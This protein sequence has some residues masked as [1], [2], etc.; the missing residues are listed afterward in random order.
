MSSP[1]GPAATT[2]MG[3]LPGEDMRKWVSVVLDVVSIPFLPELPARPYGDMVSRAAG[4][5]TQLALDLQPAGWRLTGGNDPRASLDQRRARS[6]LL[7]DLD[8]LEELAD[9]YAG[10][11]KLQVTGPW[12]LAATVELPRGDKVL[13]DHGARRDLAETLAYGLQEHVAEVRRRVPGAELV[14]QLDEPA[15]PAVLAG[16][17]PTASGWSKHRSV[18]GPGA[19]DLLS[20]VVEAVA[21]AIT[22]VHCCAARPPIEVF[23]KA[24]ADGIAVDLALLTE[25]AWEQIAFAVEADVTLYAGVVPTTGEIPHPERAAEPLTRRWSEIGLST[26]SLADVVLTPACG[27]AAAPSPADARSRLQVLRPAAEF[28]AETAQS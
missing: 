6:L 24:G 14:V 21:P 16:A 3:S 26:P 28:L 22:L 19:V 17:V 23:R 18:D 4:L 12:T 1:F 2:G 10:P 20:R 11:L 25:A 7:Q 15:L 9:G 8:V 27:L 13:A 5:L